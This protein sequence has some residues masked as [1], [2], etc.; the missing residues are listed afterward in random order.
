MVATVVAD[1]PPF[2]TMMRW[3]SLPVKK[4]VLR[5]PPTMKVPIDRWPGGG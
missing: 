5:E 1:V 4:I 2:F 3:E